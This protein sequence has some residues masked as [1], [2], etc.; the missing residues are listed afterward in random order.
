MEEVYEACFMSAWEWEGSGWLDF[1][2]MATVF[3]GYGAEYLALYEPSPEGL[4]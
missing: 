4:H 2:S 3:S 1:K